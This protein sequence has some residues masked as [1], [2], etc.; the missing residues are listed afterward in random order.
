MRF[1]KN[2]PFEFSLRAFQNRQILGPDEH[3]LKHAGVRHQDRGWRLPKRLP[4]ADLR[5]DPSLTGWQTF[6]RHA[7]VQAEANCVFEFMRPSTQAIP[8]AINEAH[9]KDR[10]IVHAPL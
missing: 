6:R 2:D 5:P 7:V 9:S 8:L 3:V 1:V 4:V 10:G